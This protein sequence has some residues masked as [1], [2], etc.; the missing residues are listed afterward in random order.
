MPALLSGAGIMEISSV[1]GDLYDAGSSGDDWSGVGRKLFQL[2]GANAGSLRVN[3]EDGRSINLFEPTAPDEALYSDHY[4]LIDPIRAAASRMVST[5]DWPSAVMVT[6]DLIP[7]EIYHRSEFYQDFA[8]PHGQR[9]ML[10]GAVG[11]REATVMGFFK[12]TSCFGNREKS[13]LATVLPH[14]Q[15]A[16]QLQR[17]LRRAEIA[18]RV[19]YSAFEALPGGAIV[20]DAD[21]NVLFANT[22]AEGT[23]CGRGLPMTIAAA[24]SPCGAGTRQLSVR[25]R[26]KAARLRALVQDAA[27]GGS[28]GAMRLEVDNGCDDRID[29]LAV[30]VSPQPPQFSA[31]DDAIGCSPPVLVLISEL[32]RP[33]APKPSLLSDL[34]G[35]SIAEGAVALALL[36]GQT[37]EC[38]AR[39]RDVSLETV[40]SQI[41][42]V[43]R[44]SDA[45]N[46]RDFERIGALLATLSH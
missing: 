35:L 41:R 39:E 21:M 40:R 43:L 26:D 12:D 5:R 6:E 30:L 4:A 46:L 28:G 19:G 45:T 37:A 2:L 16:L 44:K 3:R 14:V 13:I 25:N 20:V 22:V 38:V 36:G 27:H 1:I 31:D 15:R 32:S 18:A 34:F 7:D 33:S 9:H 24:V 29:Q 23:F 11:D 8:R 42:T 17:R 10:L